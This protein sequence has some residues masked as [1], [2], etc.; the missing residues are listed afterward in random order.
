MKEINTPKKPKRRVLIFGLVICVTALI[1]WASLRRG[2][3]FGLFSRAEAK[4]VTF[5]SVPL[6]CGAAPNIGCGSRSKPALLEMEKNSAVQ[7]AWLNREGTVIAVVWKGDDRTESVLKPIMDENSIEFLPVSESEATPLRQSFRKASVWYR[8]AGVD[9]LSREE[10][11]T[12]ASNVVQPALEAALITKE[13]AENIR[14]DVQRYFEAELVKVRTADELN[15]DS[16]TRFSDALIGIG[17]KHIGKDRTRKALELYQKCR[18]EQCT[19]K[20]ACTAPGG[21]EE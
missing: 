8:G 10:A 2:D 20:S 1:G 5:Y 3:G 15:E 19:S 4:N 13:E 16:R 12:I 11:A 14:R 6:V 18:E 9:E 21:N 7:E 17:E